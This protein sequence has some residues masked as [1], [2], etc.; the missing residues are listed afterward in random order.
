M[1][2][3][4]PDSERIHGQSINGT[5]TATQT[6]FNAK[7]LSFRADFDR[8]SF[9]FDH[10]LADSP[11][12]TLPRLADLAETLLKTGGSKSVRWQDGK[13]PVEA[14]WDVPLHKEVEHVHKAIANLQDS[15]SWVLLYSIQRDPEYKDLLDRI[16]SEVVELTGMS[17]ADVSWLD[18]Y[19][20]MASPG[21]LTPYHIDHETTF[22]FQIHGDR[23]AN[24]WDGSDRSILPVTEIENYYM[25]DMGAAIY[26]PENQRKAMTYDLRHGK[27]VHQ[28]SLAPHWFKCGEDYSIALGVHFCLRKHDAEAKTHQVNRLL[29]GLGLAPAPL[30]VFPARDRI[31]SGLL[32]LLSK[33]HPKTKFE[34]LRSGVLRLTLPARLV[35]KV[36]KKL[37]GGA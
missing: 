14:G 7:P 4:I 9:L 27:G 1:N 19:L 8:K 22:L 37:G 11:L 28:P 36:A 26:K 12:F 3:A 6:V 18:A 29:R 21:S 35:R 30:G 20:F 10:N 16:M 13:A 24:L 25:G 23:T 34:L 5:D 31:K 33:R 32:A 15:G 17:R 2:I